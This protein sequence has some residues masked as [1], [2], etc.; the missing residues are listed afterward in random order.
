MEVKILSGDLYFLSGPLVADRGQ[1]GHVRAYITRNFQPPL[2]AQNSFFPEYLDLVTKHEVACDP[3]AGG[4][5]RVLSHV[6]MGTRSDII[7]FSLEYFLSS[8]YSSTH[9]GQKGMSPFPDSL[10][11]Q[12]SLIGKYLA[13]GLWSLSILGLVSRI[14][15]LWVKSHTMT[16]VKKWHSLDF[17]SAQ[18]VQRSVQSGGTAFLL[19][20][21]LGF[22]SALPPFLCVYISGASSLYFSFFLS[23]SLA[24][25]VHVEFS[26]GFFVCL[27]FLS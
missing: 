6:S 8:S 15:Q 13:M 9:H 26:K 27:F 20:L 19:H 11:L 5:L 16:Y 25:P 24:I 4:P 14:A 1:F 17:F 18:S 3:C 23:I 7:S 22:L 10:K 12:L 21:L 2:H